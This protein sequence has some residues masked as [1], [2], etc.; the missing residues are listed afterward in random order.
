MI[1][2]TDFMRSLTI[3]LFHRW[4]SDRLFMILTAYVDESGTHD[5]SPITVMAGYVGYSGQWRK[6]EKK[7]ARQLQKFDVT[8]FH[9]KDFVKRTGE[10]KGWTVDRQ[11]EFVHG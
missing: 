1:T 8:H 3:G 5:D 10:Y 4:E 7:W 11:I 6:F 2:P 9:A